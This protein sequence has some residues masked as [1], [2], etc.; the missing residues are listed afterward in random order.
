MKNCFLLCLL[1]INSV[2]FGQVPIIEWETSI[3]GSTDDRPGNGNSLQET[4]DGGFIVLGRS[5]SS[6]INVT[7]N[8]GLFDAWVVKLSDLGNIS[9]Q[10]SFGGSGNEWMESIVQTSDGGYI[11]VGRSNSTDGDI[12]S[13]NGL[14]D[15]WVIKLDVSGNI[16]WQK[17]FGGSNYDGLNSIVQT[18]DGGYIAVGFSTSNDG[19]LTGNQGLGDAW[20]MKLDVSG[21]ISWQNS[22]GGSDY[23]EATSIIELSNG[24]Y[25][26]AGSSA[27]IDGDII[28]NH[29]SKDFW[30]FKLDSFG[31]LIWS[32]LYGGSDF[33]SP[34][35]D[36]QSTTDGGF[37]VAGRTNSNNG[38]VVGNHGLGD[39]WIIK[40]D[41][42]GNSE[43]QLCLGGSADDEI[44]RIRQK[45]NGGYLIA[46]TFYSN[47]GDISGNH[48]QDDCWIASIA[49]NG[50]IVEW[51]KSL[52][53]TA[54]DYARDIIETNNNEYL[55]LAESNSFN[56]DITQPL[57]SSDF[58]LVKLSNSSSNLFEHELHQKKELVK[59]LNL[60][61][62]EVEYTPNTLL[63]Y[64]YSN[65]TTEKIFTV[66]K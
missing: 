41:G 50:A 15:A 25:V 26:I 27:S 4:T 5:N 60:L 65:G 56:G 58:W 59:I 35:G 38:N 21:N 8:Q 47:D 64:Q 66:E 37:I 30:I 14:G 11:V 42:M 19:D 63:L 44:Q 39:G 7:S 9:W 54:S 61:G 51:Q 12:T 46:G 34:Y 23:D 31:N 53:G 13:N 52:G 17:S 6:D 10:K 22:F 36:I 45:S 24:T 55:V 29:G 43:W 57:G 16:S 3:G 2:L 49:S 62:Q 28:G 20:V 33:E 40:L 32:K 48:G 18:S 1:A